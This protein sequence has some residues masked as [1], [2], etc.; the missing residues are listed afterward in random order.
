MSIS[1]NFRESTY[2]SETARVPIMLITFDHADMPEPVYISTDAT[3]RIVVLDELVIYGTVSRG[4]NFIY[5]PCRFKL[6]DDTD[7]GPGEMSLEIDNVNR[8]LIETVRNI[9][10]PLSV[11]VEVVMDNALDTVDLEWPE[12]TLTGISYNANIITGTMTLEN[13]IRE[14]FPG[15]SFTPSTAPGIFL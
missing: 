1:L 14:P 2:L 4:T 15:L 9:H 10:T 3:Q 7:S 11:K 5:Y 13:L 8:E 12:Y 6:P